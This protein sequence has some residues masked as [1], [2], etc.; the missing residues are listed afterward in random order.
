MQTERSPRTVTPA[1]PT[2]PVEAPAPPAPP[3][4]GMRL[5]V[6]LSGI[7]ARA[8]VRAGIRVVVVTLIMLAL[9][10]AFLFG[11][12]NLEQARSQAALLTELSAVL[13]TGTIGALD[14]PIP[15]GDPVALL[16]VP[17][18]G[19]RQVIVEGSSPEELKRGPGHLPISSLPGEVGNSV[20][21]GRHSTYGGPFPEP[22]VAGRGRSDRG[23]HRPGRVRVRSHRLDSRPR[24]QTQFYLPTADS[25]LTL[26]ASASASPW[27]DR[28]AVTSQLVGNPVEIPSR[29]IATIG[30]S[31][32]GTSGDALG[33]PLA[34]F[35]R[36]CWAWR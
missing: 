33:Y 34:V 11:A 22:L 16:E 17:N 10:A 7:D 6:D 4:G 26:V 3:T 13:P 20:V 18:L 9:F 32:L 36:S 21:F 29:P 1:P 28:L 23:D 14:T 15:L 24:E 8:L 31:A 5:S 12:S 25:T 19:L 2:E 27:V 35:G 30:S